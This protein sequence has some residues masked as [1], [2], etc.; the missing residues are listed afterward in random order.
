L[1]NKKQKQKIRT[2]RGTFSPPYSGDYWF[3]VDMQGEE[4][5]FNQNQII[6][7]RLENDDGFNKQQTRI[8][9]CQVKEYNIPKVL[10]CRANNLKSN[11]TYEALL[12]YNSNMT[13]LVFFT[14][15]DGHDKTKI[16]SKDSEFIDYYIMIESDSIDQKSDHFTTKV[17]SLIAS[18]RKLTGSAVLF[19][20][21]AYGFWQ[22][23]EHYH[24]Q[25]EILQSAKRHR[26]LGIPVDN[27]VQDWHYWGSLGWGPQWDNQLYPNSDNAEASGANREIDVYSNGFKIRSNGGFVNTSGNTYIYAAFAENPFQANGGLAR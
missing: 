11:T 27:I 5:Y 3:T 21:K 6:E 9:A 2:A 19:S 20:K 13:P 8:T 7:L 16:Q 1:K 24:N 25:S 12:D 14:S 26:D 17:D 4:D 18:Y 10:V 15:I 23:K 22:C